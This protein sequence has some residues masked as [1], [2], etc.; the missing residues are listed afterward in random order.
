[1]SVQF[2]DGPAAGRFL[3][4]RRAPLLLRVTQSREGEF[5]A[6]D[7]PDDFAN[8]DETLHV[9]VLT[10]APQFVHIKACRKSQ[11]GWYAT[12]TYQL[13]KLEQPPQ[14]VLRTNSLWRGWC[15]QNRERLIPDWARGRVAR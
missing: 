15:E 3:R 10:G 14:H 13:L 12:A 8:E 1:M 7:Q 5:D 2:I 4:L 11:S 9:Y 6:L